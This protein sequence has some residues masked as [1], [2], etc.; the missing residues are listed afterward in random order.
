MRTHI[1]I[2]A[3]AAVVVSLSPFSAGAQG[4][5][6]NNEINRDLAARSTSK[7]DK[8]GAQVIPGSTTNIDVLIS[9]TQGRLREP[10]Q[11][12]EQTARFGQ[13]PYA[14]AS[15]PTSFFGNLAP[16]PDQHQMPDLYDRMTPL[17][18]FLADT[19]D[20]ALMVFIVMFCA[21]FGMR[22]FRRREALPSQVS[23]I[24]TT[25]L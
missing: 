6:V 17:G 10:G 4:N 16:N 11:A 22:G 25:A 2:A 23:S 8:A 21:V 3:M 24:P 13:T 5:A 18:Q 20:N 9:K 12:S 1:S 15:S 7:F 19:L 14:S